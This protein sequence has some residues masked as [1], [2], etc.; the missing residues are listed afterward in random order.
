MTLKRVIRIL[1]TVVLLVVIDRFIL[2]GHSFETAPFPTAESPITAY[3]ITGEEVDVRLF[4]NDPNTFHGYAIVQ[5]QAINDAALRQEV[6]GV[7][8]SRLT[9]GSDDI[10]C[11]EPGI[12]IRFGKGNAQVDA[13]ICL[14]CD[15]IYFLR[16]GEGVFRELNA[17]SV[18][19]IKGL[20]SRLFPG[21]LADGDD[22]DTQR[23][24]AARNQERES[25]YM[26]QPE[27]AS[28]PASQPVMP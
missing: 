10:M 8:N 26:G 19:R 22:E 18:H 1:L 14:H 21:H 6:I 12:G 25:R 3:R 5:E 4:A 16:G 9:Y 11:F 17:I 27:S 28:K 15:K 23:I 20:Y 2:G 24:A 7:L 13:L